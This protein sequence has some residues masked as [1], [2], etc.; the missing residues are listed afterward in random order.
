MDKLFKIAVFLVCLGLAIIVA[1]PVIVAI[2]G[3]DKFAFYSLIGLP[4]SLVG[5]YFW[6]RSI[7]NHDKR[8]TK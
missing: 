4:I 5:I 2:T 3:S 6:Y 7:K 8:F 1:N